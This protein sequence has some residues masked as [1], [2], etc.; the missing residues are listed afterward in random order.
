M[1][2]ETAVQII[3]FYSH[4]HVHTV[5]NDNSFYEE[6]VDTSTGSE[7]LPYSTV[8]VTGADTGIDNK[9]VKLTDLKTKQKL[10]GQG[11]FL[12]Y[13]QP[14][15]QADVLFNGSTNVWFCRV[16]PDNA[17]YANLIVLAH[18]RKGKILDDLGQ[19]TG[20]Y[21]LEIK[22]STVSADM[23]A[24]V[25]GAISD[26]IIEEY[27]YALTDITT[28]PLTGYL[29]VPIAYIRST[30]RGNYG[31]NYSIAITRDTDAENEYDVKMYGW[32]V[33]NNTNITTVENVISGSLYQT[34][35]NGTSTLISDVI[36]QFNEGSVPVYIHSFEDSFDTI[37]AYYKEI[38]KMN[39]EYIMASGADADELADLK[40]AMAITAEAF[41]PVFGY[42]LNT[43]NG[44]LIPYYRNYT[45]GDT[46]YVAPDFT[47]PNTMGATKPLNTTDW[48]T[49]AA[50]KTVLVVADPLNGGYRWL[51][52]V[53]SVDPDTGNIVY[54]E[55]EE[56][57]IDADQYTGV[58]LSVSA[59]IALAGGH[60]GDFEEI[61]VNGE[62]RAP[63]AAEMKLLLSREFVKAFRG[64]KDRKILS[65]AR[66]ALDFIFDA[67][68]NLT[69]SETLEIETTT[70]PLYNNSS[71]ITDQDSRAL[72]ILG[73]ASESLSF[74][75]LNVKAAMYDLNEFR[76]RNGM[77]INPN[78]EGAGTSLYLDC[79]LLGM[80]KVGVNEELSNII[81][82]MEDFTGRQTSVDLGYLSIFDPKSG[83]KVNVTVTYLLAQ[84]LV[85]HLI[86]YGLNK[87]FTYSYA[88]FT[89]IQKDKTLISSGEMIRDSFKP[90]ID[91]IDWDVKEDL[92]KS[93]INYYIVS[94]E[95]RTVQRACQNTR[96]TDASALLEENNVRV[97]NTFKKGLEEA[98]R[99]YMYEWNEPEVR[100]G[101]TQAQ[102]EK[103][104]PWIGTMVQD[105]DIYFDANEWET[106]RMIMHCYASIKFRN[107]A[108]RIILEININKPDYE[109]GES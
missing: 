28:D 8:V 19:E 59:G 87:P 20:K 70:V 101:Y 16:L 75:D 60:D 107:I 5:I 31:N 82:S 39:Y 37:F 27:A 103:Y 25:D 102:M 88:K 22:F 21:R 76:C 95:G 58:K 30:G 17:R 93:R 26:E 89:A 43:K 24:I 57:E 3:P 51:Y 38:V 104:R 62:T 45:E 50:G 61:T 55:G 69:S 98:C 35:K 99:T 13:G 83:K 4:P 64:E 56:V 7:D 14:S 106:E 2:N 12:K 40:Y 65:P 78:M 96:Q 94:N 63:S 105:L 49:A 52:T 71:V 32:N 9:F 44:D 86:K 90:E 47:V 81:T 72:S 41:D 42:Q 15:I 46:P 100:K 74:S 10:F 53:V 29:T 84:Y 66:V 92:Y 68:Y 77:T 33:I 73:V 91:L 1:A 79:G 36:D 11:D 80:K 67:N 108:K 48:A 18:Y 23:P 34:S 97:L 6:T 109:G 85:P 54:D